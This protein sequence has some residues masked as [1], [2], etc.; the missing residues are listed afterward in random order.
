MRFKLNIGLHGNKNRL[1]INYQ[2]ELSSF[3]YK[4]LQRGDMEYSKWLHNNG[5][6]L[7]G[8]PFKLFTFSN[9]IIPYRDIDKKEGRI[10]I[11]SSD[12][13]WHLSFLPE[14]STENFIK[15]IF[16]EKRFSIGDKKSKVEFYVRSIEIYPEPEFSKEMQFK[17]LTPINIS[18]KDEEGK[19]IYMDPAEEI[20][21]QAILNNLLNKYQV[22]YGKEYP[23]NIGEIDFDFRTIYESRSKLILIKAGT[24]KETKVK[25]YNCEFKIKAPV[26]L[27]KIMYRGG[28]GE[29]GSLGFGM[30]EIKG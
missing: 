15:G 22:F 28:I 13:Y 12:I 30:V 6:Q 26:D 29:K 25:G 9:F 10:I 1:P 3:I 17:T 11:K 21:K 7:K 24:P 8:K 2:Y 18:R 4:T 27:I 16:C 20:A 5:F 19:I 14:I 23:A